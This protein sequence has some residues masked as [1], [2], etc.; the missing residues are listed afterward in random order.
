MSLQ[1]TLLAALPLVALLAPLPGAAAEA[2][3]YGAEGMLLDYDKTRNVFKV[4]VTSPK[5]SGGF[6]SG[7]IA[8]KP[9]PG[10]KA[11]EELELEVVPEGSVL[12]RTVIK[13]SKGGGLDNSGTQAGFERAVGVI[14]RDRAVVLSFEENQKSEPKYL[15]KM[16]QIRMSPEEIQKRLRELGID[17]QEAE[18]LERAQQGAESAN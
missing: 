14:P 16:V 4:K 9:A 10:L 6:G 2:K 3:R 5:V 15:L 13:G 1:R 12:R 17:P 11:G 18:E 8:G 7:G